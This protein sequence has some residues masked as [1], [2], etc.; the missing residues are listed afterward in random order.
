MFSL[1]LISKFSIRI[2]EGH[3]RFRNVQIT[4]D[5]K[6]IGIKP[7]LIFIIFATFG[8]FFTAQI[9][10]GSRMHERFN[11]T[12]TIFLGILHVFRKISPCYSHGIVLVWQTYPLIIYS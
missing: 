1:A 7:L 4:S 9:G 6:I 2:W 10:F 3:R 8:I 11:R 12:Q 5:F